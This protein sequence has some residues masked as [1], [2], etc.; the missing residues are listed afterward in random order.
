MN[1]GISAAMEDA[2]DVLGM[3]SRSKMPTSVGASS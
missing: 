1:L 2:I 3:S